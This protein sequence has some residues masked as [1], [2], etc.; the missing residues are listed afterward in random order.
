MFGRVAAG[1]GAA[2]VVLAAG[3][4]PGADEP[5]DVGL[6]PT[7][8]ATTPTPNS[9]ENCINDPVE[10]APVDTG[11]LAGDVLALSRELFSCTSHV[12]VVDGTD[13]EA[14]TAG[15]RLAAAH[16]GPVLLPDAGL[17]EELERLQP[18]SVHLVGDVET[19]VPDGTEVH[20][21][22]VEE[23]ESRAADVLGEPSRA[24]TPSPST[25]SVDLES[26]IPGLPEPSDAGLL[27]LVDASE[28]AAALATGALAKAAGVGVVPTE[29]GDLFADPEASEALS[30]RPAESVRP[31][32]TFPETLGW[33]LRVLASGREQ[34]GGG[35]EVFPDDPGRR[36]VALYGHPASAGMG[37]LGQQDGPQ[38]AL[39]RLEPLVKEYAADGATV[40]PTFNL[41]AT[42]A[43][44]GG[45]TDRPSGLLDLTT[46]SY[47]DYS[48]M[49]PPETY[50][51]WVDAAAKADGYV[52]LDFQPGRNDFLFQVQHYEELLREPHVGIGLDPEWR[53][54]PRERH[55]EQIGSVTAAEINDV[56]NWIA[57]IVRDEGLPQK[58]VVIQQFRM[59]MIEDREDIVDRP[60]VAVAIQM[61][62]EGQ[63][64]LT[65]KDESYRTVTAG[66][67][68]AHWRWGWKNFF[69]RDHPDGP[70]S[71][72]QI[73][74]KDPVPAYVTY[75]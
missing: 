51:E 3:C 62:G 20:R 33:Q 16:N 29:D 52:V 18:N 75:Q 50:R 54:G 59:H 60:E 21:L 12:V 24:A 46:P 4:I 67:E 5:E 15:A 27:W 36:F 55:L 73:L 9:A 42:V 28:P 64:S 70:Y 17:S 1:F 41:I 69:E 39:E 14:A 74:A 71:P 56:I 13:I 66:T 10:T 44:N 23:V 37:A 34:P 58:L 49:H 72:E 26:L 57:D 45:S 53:L 47:V 38:D 65:T 61:D 6:E 19:P 43:H 35:Y 11:S 48:T 25:A 8:E 7:R 40:V 31:I 63:G 32:G 68:D 2:A 22:T 30:G